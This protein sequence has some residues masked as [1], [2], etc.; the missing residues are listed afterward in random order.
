MAKKKVKD[1]GKIANRRAR[2]DYHIGD[3]IIAGIALSGKETKSLRLGLGQ[4]KGSYVVEKS[5]EFW[6]VNCQITGTHSFKIDDK[7]QTRDRKLLIKKSEIESLGKA[8]KQGNTIIPLEILTKGRFIKLK[9][10]VAR[11]KKQ[12]D[13]REAIK[14]H[15]QNRAS[16]IEL[17]GRI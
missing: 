11:G 6:L 1:T 2:F 7:D 4:L 13:K 3:E 9:I 16:K 5:G 10:A 8:K 15:D 14:K 17:K 12:Y